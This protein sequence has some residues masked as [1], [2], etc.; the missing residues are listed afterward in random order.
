[1]NVLELPSEAVELIV[2]TP[3]MER[4]ADSTSWVIWF[5]I[6]VG[7]APGCEMLTLTAGNS[8]SGLLTTSIDR[9]LSTP[10]NSRAVKITSGM[11]GLRI[12]QAE[13]LRK[14]MTGQSSSSRMTGS[15]RSPGLRKPPARS[16]IRSLPEMPLWI[17]IPRE[18]TIPVSTGRR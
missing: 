5:S 16:T 15:T 2:F 12:D 9:K 8:M 14:S 3:L 4:T 6:S 11:T 7:A 13:M 10:A 18:V 17:A 1:M